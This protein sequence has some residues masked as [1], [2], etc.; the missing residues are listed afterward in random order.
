[1]TTNNSDE[2]D[3][4]D[5]GRWFGTVPAWASTG[6]TPARELAAGLT[7]AG[8]VQPAPPVEVADEWGW[9][10]TTDAPDTADDAVSPP[11][12]EAV[13]AAESAAPVPAD[14]VVDTT[15]D[16]LPALAAG[17]E[18]A[19]RPRRR[20]TLPGRRVRVVV[21]GVAA[22][23]VVTGVLAAVV[24]SLLGGASEDPQ[25]RD[26]VAVLGATSSAPPPPA[27]E[28]PEQIDGPVTVG[29]DEGDQTSGPGVIKAFDYA[30]YVRR[31]GEA[32]RAVAT[33][34]GVG[35]T[36]DLQKSIDARPAGTRHCLRITDRGTGL[37]AVT[38]TETQPDQAQ[39]TVYRQLIQ[40]VQ[41]NGKTWIASISKDES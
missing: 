3:N 18:P 25:P 40:T 9:L 33:P 1:M 28:C 8:F 15:V 5:G 4:I 30:Y 26:P 39:P 24:G 31:S 27:D 29:N 20:V 37:Y 19:A 7:A 17:P 21:A 35:T 38:L 10:A 14:P 13:V 41:A 23:V 6:D 22:V 11:A 32:A 16:D 12:G 34:N 2:T 36:T